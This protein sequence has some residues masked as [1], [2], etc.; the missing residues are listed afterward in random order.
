[1]GC[2]RKTFSKFYRRH[3]ES[4]SRF[5]VGLETLLREGPS[6]PK[7]Y[8][9]LVYKSKKLIERNVFFLFSSGVGVDARYRRMGGGLNFMRQSACL[10]FN[11]IMV[12]NY[13]AFFNC[14]LVGRASNS[15]LAP[16]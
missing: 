5:N 14:S 10:V 13:A 7:F 15:M 8:G 9:D 6:K 11:Q 4:I 16:T 2:R 1:M 3:C 12:D